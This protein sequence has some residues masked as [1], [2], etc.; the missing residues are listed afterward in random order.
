MSP[1]CQLLREPRDPTSKVAWRWDAGA[2]RAVCWA[3][4]RR[5]VS[6]LRERLAGEPEGAWVL[7]TEDAYSFAVGLMA[8]WHSGR[9]AVSP[10]NRQDG[11]L[12]ALQ[13]R[14]AGVL[15]DRPDWFRG[16]SVIHPLGHPSRRGIDD[17]TPLSPDALAVELFTSGTTG[18]EKP[19]TKRIRH[20]ADEVRELMATWDALLG[21][22]TV[23]ATASHQHLYGLLFGV[24]WPLC[25]GRPFHAQH[26]LHVG[27]LAPRIRASEA[28][29]LASVPTHLNRLSRQAE[30]ATLEGR[31]RAVFSSGGPLSA[32][33]AH[34][35]K[36]VLGRSPLE[37]LGSTETGGIAW[38]T[39]DA[40]KSDDSWT[41][42]TGV[43]VTCSPCSSVMRVG[44]PFVSVEGAD[45]GYATG[46]T[47]SLLPNG[48]FQL[49]GR[50]DRVVKIGEKRLDLVRMESQIQEDSGV[51]EVALATVDRDTDLR[52]AA[53]VVPSAEGWELI[54]RDGR[55]AFIRTMR[56]RLAK[57]WDP[58]LHPR[59][60][61]IETA[62]PENAQG[63]ITRESL[64]QL[65]RKPDGDGPPSDPP[66]VI[67]E[68]RGADYLERLCLVPRDLSCF[69]GHFPDSPVVP[70]VLQL[71]WAMEL[72][73]ELLEETPRLS[74]ID[75]L[76]LLAPLRP[77]CRF[78]IKVRITHGTRI[79]FR[80][81]YEDTEFARGQ[82]RLGATGSR[83]P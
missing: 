65:F 6:A 12:R 3:E 10:P 47:I 44:S 79:H 46:D 69:P 26:F 73:A 60:W 34:R 83:E 48:R 22:A 71:D 16:G 54:Q 53:A 19:V 75:S 30:T 11:S 45:D 51:G 23:F 57:D 64:D 55:R 77:E 63:K 2:D 37:I 14:T 43:R 32:P 21:D 31:I 41:P 59:H 33:T 27:E 20:L 13:T 35:I 49:E 81:W 17:I 68:S 70:G 28:S 4:F 42:L 1:L 24:L 18:A 15:T 39:Q 9:H 8:L 82:V 56:T 66:E 61:R 74:A 29:V 36:E 40:G 78:R 25:A 76:K 52:V 50:L 80:I 7:F 38:R 5:H 62:L 72:A 58:A 67:E